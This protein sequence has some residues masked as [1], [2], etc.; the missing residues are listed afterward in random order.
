[1]TT[2]FLSFKLRGILPDDDEI[3]KMVGKSAT[4]I[5]R[6]GDLIKLETPK[7][8]QEDLWILDLTTELDN[9]QNTTNEI[10]EQ[11]LAGAKILE[12]I[13]SNINQISCDEFTSELY[14][15]I[16]IEESQGGFTLP[17]QLIHAAASAGLP[18]RMSIIV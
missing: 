12:E 16:L 17:I 3:T 2:F 7:I 1:M 8:Q 6:K 4:E 13:A 11:L 18:I 15:S 9:Y 10:I 5:F 14:I